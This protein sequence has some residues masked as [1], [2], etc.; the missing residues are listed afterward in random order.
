[1]GTITTTLRRLFK[2]INKAERRLLDPR[3]DV[4]PADSAKR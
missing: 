2:D 3:A 1:M 4:R